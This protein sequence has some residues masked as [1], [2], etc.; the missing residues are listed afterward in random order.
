MPEAAIC[1][2]VRRS[3]AAA[4]EIT[5]KRAR[6]LYSRAV[7]IRMVVTEMTSKRAMPRLLPIVLAIFTIS[8]SV[9]SRDMGKDTMVS[10]VCD[11]ALFVNSSFM[12][13]AFGVA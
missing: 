11:A 4:V 6:R 9:G 5:A 7:A 2:R 3:R 12:P 1:D 8:Y 10:K 13:I